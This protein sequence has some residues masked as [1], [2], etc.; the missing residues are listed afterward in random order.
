VGVVAVILLQIRARRYTTQQRRGEL[1]EQRHSWSL[2]EKNSPS[3]SALSRKST[4]W[5]EEREE[6]QTKGQVRENRG[7]GG[8][9]KTGRWQRIWYEFARSG[10]FILPTV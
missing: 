10:K 7:G 4:I 3:L 5:W 2:T 6:R 8:K 9:G 1:T